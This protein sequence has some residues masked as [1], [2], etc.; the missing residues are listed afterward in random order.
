VRG[1]PSGTRVSGVTLQPTTTPS[2]RDAFVTGRY[3]GDRPSAYDLDG[4]TTIRS[5]RIQLPDTTG[6]RLSFRWFLGHGASASAADHL[7]AIVEDAAGG[8]TVVWERTGRP[9]V[10]AGV[11]RSASVSMDRWAGTAIRIRFEALDGAAA[12][13][14]DTGVD[15]VRVTRPPA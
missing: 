6:Q 15:D 13:T 1:N 11:W 5:A 4:R 7:R 10:V 14:I 9:E 2:G 3:A 12:S 8:Q